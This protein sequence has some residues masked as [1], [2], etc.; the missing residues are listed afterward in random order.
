MKNS[1]ARDEIARELDVICFEMEAAGLMDVLPCL[2]IRGICDYSDSHKSKEWQKYAAA[3]AAAYAR[4]FVETLRVTSLQESVSRD[5]ASRAQARKQELRARILSS[6]TFDGIR[7]RE[8][9]I[10]PAYAGTCQWILDHDAY[11]KWQDPQELTNHHG[12]MWLRGKPGAG[13]STIMKFAYTN[14]KK[15]LRHQ[16]VLLI[17]FFFHAR[18]VYLERSVSG[19]YRSLLYQLLRGYQE[20]QTVLDDVDDL[21]AFPSTQGLPLNVFKELF[22]QS[23]QLLGGRSLICFIDALDECDEQEVTDMLQFFEELAEDTIKSTTQVR[24]FFS[25]R[26]YPYIHVRRCVRLTL[27]KQSSHIGDLTTYVR[28]HL[29]V[30]DRALLEELEGQILQ[31]ASGVFLWVILIVKIL[32][33]EYRNG[34]MAIRKRLK[35]VPPGLT[36]LFKNILNRDSENPEQS[37]L[38]V[39]W[40]LFAIR[41]LNP[42]EYYHALWSGL[43]LS[44]LADF[45]VPDVTSQDADHRVVGFVISSSKVYT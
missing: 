42:K 8:I 19:M 32:N 22:Q 14:M 9:D 21:D 35:E 11:Q 12:F 1:T 28:R 25:S 41:P 18:G 15:N 43:S 3:T 30:N 39:L 23:V 2:P 16:N 36:E 38:S 34:A 24:I 37:L 40:I 44:S 4:D 10:D 27:E 31:K 7:S 20:L 45:N 6:L 5:Y 29:R 17:S 26:H 13:K 33:K